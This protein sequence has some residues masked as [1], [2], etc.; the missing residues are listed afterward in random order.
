MYWLK[1]V[2]VYMV[3][4]YMKSI[5]YNYYTYYHKYQNKQESMQEKKKERLRN[6]NQL[7]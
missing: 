7:Q 5:Y 4:D 2:E 6:L 3:F 1:N